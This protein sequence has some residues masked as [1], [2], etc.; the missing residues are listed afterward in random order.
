MAI[1]RTITTFSREERR[2][3]SQSQRTGRGFTPP[4]PGQQR[5]SSG[6][7]L[8]LILLIAAIIIYAYIDAYWLAPQREQQQKKE[9][10]SVSSVLVMK[11]DGQGVTT[12]STGHTPVVMAPMC[13]LKLL[14]LVPAHNTGRPNWTGTQIG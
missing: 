5:R 8:F 3:M 11:T 10:S 12:G 13:V 9:S 7:C 4:G 6:C 14:Y 1:D 2:R